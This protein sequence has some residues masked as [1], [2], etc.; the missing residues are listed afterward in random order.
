MYTTWKSLPKWLQITAIVLLCVLVGRLVIAPEKQHPVINAQTC[1]AKNKGPF[2]GR[3]LYACT[4][5]KVAQV[6]KNLQSASEANAF[7]AEWLHKYDND[8]LL[9]TEQ[10]TMQALTEMLLSVKARFDYVFT[11]ADAEENDTTVKG[12][13]RGIGASIAIRNSDAVAVAERIQLPKHTTTQLLAFLVLSKQYKKPT[14]ALVSDQNPLFVALDPEE[15]TPAFTAGIKKGDLIYAIDNRQVNGMSLGAVLD[16]VRGKPGSKVNLTIVRDGTKKNL[17]IVRAM[18]NM[19]AASQR[20]IGDV[21]YLRINHFESPRV[22]EDAHSTF[23]KLC[24]ND[25]VEETSQTCDVSALIL[26]LRYNPGG[27]V[28]VVALISELFIEQGNLMTIKSR[29]GNGLVDTDITLFADRVHIKDGSKAQDQRRDFPLHFPK[30]KKLIV[31]VDEY[32]VSGAEA[33]AKMLQELRGAVVVGLQTKGKGIGQ[34]PVEL[35]FGYD[36]RI[37]CMEYLVNGK[38]VDWVGVT[39]D[40]TVA[41]AAA[42]ASGVAENQDPQL[43]TALRIA[44]GEQEVLKPDSTNQSDQDA[45]I[46]GQRKKEYDQEIADT[47]RRFFRK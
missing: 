37:I 34:C 3:V 4:V 46:I 23:D 16:L 14:E 32:T 44:R 24:G 26:D 1:S 36:A 40:V 18:V 30:D 5:T 42:P 31:L 25:K 12:Q 47:L 39:P 21:G 41:H 20:K 8:S 15:D 17:E 43:E 13:L 27:I 29:E 9:D 19:H 38:P 6:H 22:V 45:R 10:G 35:P 28:D 33:L 11:P 7:L 2:D